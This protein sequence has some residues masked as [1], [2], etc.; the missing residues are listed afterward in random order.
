MGK[1][2]AGIVAG[3]FIGA[4]AVEVLKRKRPELILEIENRAKD[5]VDAFAAR[6]VEAN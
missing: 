5:F 2:L 1:T 6:K 4:F 3:I